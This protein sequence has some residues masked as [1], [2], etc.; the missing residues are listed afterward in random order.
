[1]I[2]RVCSLASRGV[3]CKTPPFGGGNFLSGNDYG[4]DRRFRA[5]TKLGS[6]GVLTSRQERFAMQ[7]SAL[8]TDSRSGLIMGDFPF[9]LS[10]N[11]SCKPELW[12]QIIWKNGLGVD[13]ECDGTIP[14]YIPVIPMRSSRA[15]SRFSSSWSSLRPTTPFL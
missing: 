1:M 5:Q 12:L 9:C 8:P 6:D 2:C 4:R 14:L 13:P 7:L 3:L 11:R 15:C 10:T